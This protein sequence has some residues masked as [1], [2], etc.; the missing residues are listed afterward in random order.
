MSSQEAIRRKELEAENARLKKLHA[1]K[2][3]DIDMLKEV[4]WGNF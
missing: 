2:E 3:L 1:E 4:S